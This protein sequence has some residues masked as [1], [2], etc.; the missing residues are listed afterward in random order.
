MVECC[1]RNIDLM[2][3]HIFRVTL[4]ILV[5]VCEACESEIKIKTRKGLSLTTASTRYQYV[6]RPCSTDSKHGPVS[7]TRLHTTVGASF[8]GS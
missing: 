5:K 8:S 4:N 6:G 2:T 1:R 3:L 7:S